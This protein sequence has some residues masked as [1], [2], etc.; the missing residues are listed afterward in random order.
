M[1]GKT[2]L[3]YG[4]ASSLAICTDI[5]SGVLLSVGSIL[6]D[7]DSRNSLLGKSLPFIP[8][9][10]KHRTITHSLLFIIGCYFINYYLMVGCCVHLIL[11]MM[12]K[13]GCPLLYPFNK[14]FRF[15]LAGFVKTDGKFEKLLF[16]IGL[17]YIMYFIVL[18][19]LRYL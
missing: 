2:H 8:K 4:I 13:Q 16:F 11:D 5:I 7:I 9:L 15:P 6:P 12:T 3:L 19:L 10:I 17:I 1:T 14:K 18:Y